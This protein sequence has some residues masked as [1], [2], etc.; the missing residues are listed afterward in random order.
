MTVRR[1]SSA[2]RQPKPGPTVPDI[3]ETLEEPRAALL[4]LL[5][6]LALAL[7]GV[8]ERTVYDGFCRHWTPAYYLGDRQLFHVHNFKRGLRA[9]MFVSVRSL[10]PLILDSEQV[11][12]QLRQQLVQ[13]SGN[14]GTKMFKVAI[15]APEDVEAFREM[16]LIKWELSKDEQG[17]IGRSSRRR[18]PAPLR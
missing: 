9:S 7:S 15:D 17:A 13:T 2:G 5:R 1:A 12:G 8:D 11:D 4:G 18:S 10:E 16:V 3:I 14:R 6:D